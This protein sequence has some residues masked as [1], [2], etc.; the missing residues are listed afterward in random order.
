MLRLLLGRWHVVVFCEDCEA[1]PA[2]HG[3][4]EVV[5]SLLEAFGTAIE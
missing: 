1:L 2:G 5:R 3:R 4:D